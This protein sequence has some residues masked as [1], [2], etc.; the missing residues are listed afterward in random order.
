MYSP[1]RYDKIKEWEILMQTKR[2]SLVETVTSTCIGL[3]V[4]LISNLIIFH[5]MKVPLSMHQNV[6]M[7]LFFTFVSIVRGYLVRRLFN[8]I[9][10]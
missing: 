2:M 1:H 8:R 7:T 4:S 5:L 3:V 9:S 10:K 6:M